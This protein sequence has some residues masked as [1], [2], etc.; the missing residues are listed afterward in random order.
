MADPQDDEVVIPIKKVL[1]DE[2]IDVCKAEAWRIQSTQDVLIEANLRGIRDARQMRKVEVFDAIS[3]FLDRV[4]IH[5]R[6]I[7]AILTGA[8]TVQ[9]KR[10]G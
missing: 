4:K 10:R 5:E 7:N 2:M 9:Y 8:A 3:L 1:I 6:E